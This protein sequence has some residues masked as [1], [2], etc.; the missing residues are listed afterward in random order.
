MERAVN[1]SWHPDDTAWREALEQGWSLREIEREYILAVLARTA[2]RSIA[3]SERWRSPP[4]ACDACRADTRR[5]RPTP[6]DMRP[7]WG[8]L[9]AR[10]PS[11]PGASPRS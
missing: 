5:R 2:G 3:S 8:R 11:V 7:R 10:P 9:H 4:G 1:A 6:H